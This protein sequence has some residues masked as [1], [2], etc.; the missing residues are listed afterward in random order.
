MPIRFACPSC[1]QPIEIDDQWAGQSVACPYCRNVVSA[2]TTSTWQTPEIPMARGAG[3]AFAPPPPPRDAGYSAPPATSS[4]GW[5]LTLAIV[6]AVL[7]FVGGMVWAVTVS[8][9]IMDRLGPNAS[10]AEITREY[11]QMLLNKT[12]PQSPFTSMAA[13]VGLLCAIG[14]LILGLRSLARREPRRGVAIAAVAV[15]VVFLMC[16]VLLGMVVFAAATHGG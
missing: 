16:Q 14:G 4:A 11:Q 3:G 2:P 5:A 12:L 10:Q 9:V 13:I 8:S 15:S 6:S 7:A 1:R